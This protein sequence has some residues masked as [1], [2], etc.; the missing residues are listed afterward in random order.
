MTEF[1]QI[2]FY[3]TAC[4]N[5]KVWLIEVLIEMTIYEL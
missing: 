5:N 1:D 3:K 2:F 4:S